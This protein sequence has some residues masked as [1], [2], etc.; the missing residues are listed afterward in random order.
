MRE[1]VDERLLVEK[2]AVKTIHHLGSRV[3]AVH[4]DKVLDA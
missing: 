4:R 1:A 2:E 3:F